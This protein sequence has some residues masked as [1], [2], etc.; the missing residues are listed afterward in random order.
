MRYG[1]KSIQMNSRQ[2]PDYQRV[3]QVKHEAVDLA[4]DETRHGDTADDGGRGEEEEHQGD[5]GV[6]DAQVDQQQA[7]GFPCLQL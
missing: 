7:A 1:Q 4:D 5:D 2:I 6:G 3:D